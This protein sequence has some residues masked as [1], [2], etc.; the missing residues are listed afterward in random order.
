M[1]I[2]MDV[3]VAQ[4]RRDLRLEDAAPAKAANLCR[5]PMEGH[6]ISQMRPMVCS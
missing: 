3:D 4:G 5:A 6:T 1:S 2:K